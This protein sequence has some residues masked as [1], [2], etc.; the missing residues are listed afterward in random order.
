MKDKFGATLES[1]RYRGKVGDVE[2]R[3]WG[4]EYRGQQ[5]RGKDLALTYVLHPHQRR[6][7]S[8]ISEETSRG[9]TRGLY[10]QGENDRK[11]QGTISNDKVMTITS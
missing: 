5:H 3:V 9:D 6:K 4:M 2:C 8:L 10:C 11:G 7:S 1:G